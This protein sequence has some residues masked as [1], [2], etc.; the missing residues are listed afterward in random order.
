MNFALILRQLSET[1]KDKM[2]VPAHIEFATDQNLTAVS[3][4]VRSSAKK[5]IPA[6]GDTL[7]LV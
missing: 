6:R 5:L 1:T 3:T 7:G 2:S 4:L